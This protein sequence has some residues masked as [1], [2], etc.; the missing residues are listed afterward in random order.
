[1]WELTAGRTPEEVVNEF[2]SADAAPTPPPAAP[3][4]EH[5]AAAADLGAD[6]GTTAPGFV[7]FL[8]K[9]AQICED[10]I[11][12]LARLPKEAQLVGDL[13]FD[14]L[15]DFAVPQPPTAERRVAWDVVDR[16]LGGKS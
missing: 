16:V 9:Q 14:G 15:P 8:E 12:Q 7:E 10:L 5:V 4:T 11:D 6:F 3:E 13:R 2:L 1:M